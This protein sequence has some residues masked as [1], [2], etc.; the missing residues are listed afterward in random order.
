M[1]NPTVGTRLPLPYPNSSQIP[2]VSADM[3]LLAQAAA[4]VFDTKLMENNYKWANAAA[5]AAQLG[6]TAGDTGD[7]AD[8]K[9]TYRYDGSNWKCTSSG[10]IPIVAQSISGTGVSITPG[11]T[12]LFTGATSFSLNNCFTTEFDNYKILFDIASTSVA[13]AVFLVLRAAGADSITANYDVQTASASGATAAATQSLA[14]TSLGLNGATG[15][16]HDYSIEVIAP[17]L[18]TATRMLVDGLVTTNPLT[19]SAAWQKRALLHRLTSSFDGFSVNTNTGT[20]T[21]T[22]RIYGYNNN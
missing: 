4:A 2:D 17:F 16:I 6:M 7:Q 19:T 8:L 22:L 12:V 10:L 11:G 18:A 3:L 5:R 14:S 20:I 15:N 1:A 21:G 13:N 9:L